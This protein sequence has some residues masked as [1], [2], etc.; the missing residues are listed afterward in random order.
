MGIVDVT[1]RASGITVNAGASNAV[2]LRGL[3][4]KGIGFGSG[5]GIVFNSGKSLTIENCAILR[6][7]AL[8]GPERDAQLP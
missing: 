8:A 6:I 4:I 5:N 3:T 7:P 1:V 2:S